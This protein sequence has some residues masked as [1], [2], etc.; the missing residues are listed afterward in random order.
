MPG[1]IT[2]TNFQD[3]IE[4]MHGSQAVVTP[5]ANSATITE[6]KIEKHWSVNLNTLLLFNLANQATELPVIYSSIAKGAQKQEKAMLQAGFPG[7]ATTAP[8]VI[9]KELTTTLLELICWSSD[10]GRLD[11]GLHRFFTTYISMAKTSQDQS[12]MSLYDHLA[13]EGNLTLKG[14]T[15]L[16]AC[17][18]VTLAQQLLAA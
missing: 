16:Q 10:L 7:T 11:E 2:T 4:T 18:Q 6:A 3:L 15:A 9:T 13:A 14:G 8:L 1:A 12:N 17:A 5:A